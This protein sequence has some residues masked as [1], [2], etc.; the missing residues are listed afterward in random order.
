MESIDLIATEKAAGSTQRRVSILHDV[1]YRVPIGD[2]ALNGKRRLRVLDPFCGRGTTVFAA[3]LL[4][5]K[6]TESMHLKSR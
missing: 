5:L 1:P 3:R 4:G 6:G 2:F